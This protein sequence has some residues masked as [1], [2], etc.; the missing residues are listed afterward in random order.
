MMIYYNN[1]I[2]VG[3]YGRTLTY[4]ELL[5][6]FLYSDGMKSNVLEFLLAFIINKNDT[7][8]QKKIQLGKGFSLLRPRGF[9]SNDTGKTVMMVIGDD[10]SFHDEVCVKLKE[11]RKRKKQQLDDIEYIVDIL[12]GSNDLNAAIG[13]FVLVIISL[14]KVMTD[15]NI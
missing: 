11:T 3:R 8:S 12:I 9:V 2:I 13:T 10:G 7:F 14:D 15:F 4:S 1:I 5:T 6:N